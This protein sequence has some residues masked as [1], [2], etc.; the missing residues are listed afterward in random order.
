MGG[1]LLRKTAARLKRLQG[2]SGGRAGFCRLGKNTGPREGLLTILRQRIEAGNARIGTARRKKVG[3]AGIQGQRPAGRGSRPFHGGSRDRSA[4]R[5]LLEWI[6]ARLRPFGPVASAGILLL[7][8]IMIAEAVALVAYRL[9]F[10]AT[11]HPW[12]LALVAALTTCAVAAP[13]IFIFVSTVKSLDRS[14]EQY[15]RMRDRALAESQAKSMFLA[16]MNHELRTPLNAIIGF[17][18]AMQQEIH[19][20]LGH[21]RYAEYVEDIAASGLRLSAL[22][23][24]ILEIARADSGLRPG[25]EDIFAPS[26]VIKEAIASVRRRRQATGI[27]IRC[28]IAHDLSELHADRRQV[29]RALCHILDNALKFTSAKGLI[30]LSAS[31]R[32][33]DGLVISIKDNGKGME[34]NEIP[35]VVQPFY[36]GQNARH[37]E[38]EGVGLGL[39][40]AK[41]MMEY[42]GGK[43]YIESAPGEGTRVDLVFPA[44]RLRRARSGGRKA[45]ACS[46]AD[47]RA[48]P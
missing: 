1:A 13:L 44:H 46:A 12:P 34:M 41:A 11:F 48:M 39:S 47:G 10:P 4:W 32:A 21:A 42:H 30:R 15:R 43:L 3:R 25:D 14:R 36:K 7:S 31:E 17:C 24:D 20:P 26:A 28:S 38:G 5:S 45:S 33:G 35:L 23:D 19:G 22:I 40:L 9:F 18:Q 16:H 6:N 29:R 2:V 37:G 27:K 8:A